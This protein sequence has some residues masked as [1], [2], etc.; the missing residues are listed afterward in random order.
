MSKLSIN[1]KINWIV[2]QDQL[3]CKFVA[4]FQHQVWVEGLFK[5]F[6]GNNETG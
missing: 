1:A 3:G 6:S 2:P 4:Q 5:K